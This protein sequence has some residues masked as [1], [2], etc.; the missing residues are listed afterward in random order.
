MKIAFYGAAGEV[1]GSCYLVTT[2]RA[3]VL[4]DCGIFQGAATDLVRNA[5]PEPFDP[6]D[7]SAIV[8]THAHADHTGRL[9]KLVR[10][11]LRCPLYCTQP[12]IML[13]DLLLRDAAEIQKSDVMRRNRKRTQRECPPGRFCEPLFT[14]QQVAQTIAMMRAVALDAETTI[15]PGVSVRFVDSGHIIGSTS[16]VLTLTDE[17]G[18]RTIVFSGDIG[19]PGTPIIKDPIAP[20]APEADL[21]IVES[22]YGDRDHKP[23]DG[24][25]EE[26]TAILHDARSTGGKVLIPSFA[27]GRTQTLIYDLGRLWHAGRIPR[28]LPVFIDSP[29]AIEATR[30]YEMDPR[31]FDDETRAIRDHG[32]QPLRFPGLRF[33]RSGE[34]SRT[35]NKLKGPAVVIAGA[36]M[37]T[38][39]RIVHHLLNHLHDTRTHVVMVGYQ[40]QNTLGHRIIERPRY[41]RIM[42]QTVPVNAQIH[43]LGGLSAHAGQRDLM[44]WS[45]ATITGGRAPG[46]PLPRVILTHGERGPRAALAAKLKAELGV[47]CTLPVFGDVV[48]L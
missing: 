12:T 35:I 34:E 16:V 33:L 8:V 21:V 6:R 13:S 44:H 45:R 17:N 40:A 9:P 11:G 1:T 5:R 24:T 10:D 39:G 27:V 14:E 26:L 38:G 48:S 20:V 22:T 47:D 25:I 2:S 30:L 4:V 42:G 7:L 18:T 28:D 41:V 46:Q 3:R 43:T 31:L 29:L 19:N 36:G 23:L 32:E 15:A 37:C